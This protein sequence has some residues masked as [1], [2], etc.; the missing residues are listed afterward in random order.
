[1]SRKVYPLTLDRFAD[2]GA[3]CGSCLF[4]ELDPVRRQRVPTAQQRAAKQAWLGEVLREWGPCGQVAVVDDR[5]VG[6]VIYV[7]DRFAPGAS[8]FPTSPVSEDAVLLTT[9]RVDPS[10]A[11]GGLGRM[12]IQAMARDL[13]QRGG[14]RAVEAFGDVGALSGLHGSRC[15]APAE[16]LARVGFTTYRPHATAPRMRMELSSAI[17]WKDAALEKVLGVVRPRPVAHPVPAPR[18]P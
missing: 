17:T 13:I 18:N 7:P 9:I 4:W 16:F 15:A 3:P 6:H 14:V 2:L 10:Y 1:M 12:L 5:T 8:S 11:G